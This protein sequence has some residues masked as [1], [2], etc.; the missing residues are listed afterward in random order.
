MICGSVAQLAEH[1]PFKV[2]VAGSN[3][4]ALTRYSLTFSKNVVQCPQMKISIF[5]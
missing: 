5:I 1:D 2:V 3:P 4:A